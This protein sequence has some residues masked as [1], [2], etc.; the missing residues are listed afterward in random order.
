[1]KIKKVDN[2][3]LRHRIYESLRESITS[4]VLQPGQSLSLRGIAEQSGVSVMPVREALWQ[5][6]S[7]KVIVIESNK[8]IFVNKL[9]SSQMEEILSVRLLI[10]T[11]AAQIA[12]DNITDDAIEE[13]E[14][15]L[16]SMTSLA[17]KPKRFL[18]RNRDF[19]FFIYRWAQSPVRLDILNSLW[20][21]TGPY[22]HIYVSQSEN[23]IR[24]ISCHKNILDALKIRDKE[25]IALE[26]RRDIE[27]AANLITPYL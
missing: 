26:L 2:K 19:H 16:E 14:F 11:E 25:R 3:T 23:L 4:G 27:T 9:T 10:E 15:I 18:S 6:E 7:E 17:T 12:C 13:L 20:A 21:R 1:V 8:R 22:F 5:L 24:S